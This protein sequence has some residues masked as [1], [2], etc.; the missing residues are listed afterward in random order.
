MKRE[1]FV[2]RL[3]RLTEAL[4]QVFGRTLDRLLV[5]WHIVD[6]ARKAHGE[7]SWRGR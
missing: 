7:R 2:P 5:P 6:A 4:A 1:P 3:T